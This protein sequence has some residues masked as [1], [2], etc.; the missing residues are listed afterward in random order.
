MFECIESILYF[1]ITPIKYK[2]INKN[3][4]LLKYYKIILNSI[5]SSR[6]LIVIKLF[7]LKIKF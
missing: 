1:Y 4:F 6:L 5:G 7:N 2:I 3:I